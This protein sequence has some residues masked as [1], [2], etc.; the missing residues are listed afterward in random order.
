MRGFI[1]FQQLQ[2]VN[3]VH[4]QGFEHPRF[5][6]LAPENTFFVHC[7]CLCHTPAER[8][9]KIHKYEQIEPLSTFKLADEYL[10]E[11]YDLV[12]HNAKC[13]GL[14]EFA[15]LFDALPI[16]MERRAPRV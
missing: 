3:R 1:T 11:L 6:P 4:T 16:P 2:Y 14:D 7:N 9:E 8:W 12:Y 5:C 10:P 13:D 15:D